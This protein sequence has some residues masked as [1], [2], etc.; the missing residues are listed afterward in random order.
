MKNGPVWIWPYIYRSLGPMIGFRVHSDDGF[1][2][3]SEYEPVMDVDLYFWPGEAF[4]FALK[5]IWLCW[6]IRL[7]RVQW[8]VKGLWRRK[9]RC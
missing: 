9:C 4:R 5:L 2:M 6:H 1:G 3:D 7:I 8:L